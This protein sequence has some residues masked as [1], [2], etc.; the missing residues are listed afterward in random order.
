MIIWIKDNNLKCNYN[1]LN[2]QDVSISFRPTPN[3]KAM[4]AP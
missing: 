2:N 4:R 3:L 1:G